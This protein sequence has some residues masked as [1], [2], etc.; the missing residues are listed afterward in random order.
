MFLMYRSDTEEEIEQLLEDITI[1]YED[2]AAE[3]EVLLA[4]KSGC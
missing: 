3:K 2:V 4:K 1:F